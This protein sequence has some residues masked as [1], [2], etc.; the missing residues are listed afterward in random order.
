[1]YE[2]TRNMENMHR[3]K[4]PQQFLDT[5][6]HNRIRVVSITKPYKMK[7]PIWYTFLSPTTL[8]S[9]KCP[10][11]FL[12]VNAAMASRC[13]VAS[14]SVVLLPE[15]QNREMQQLLGNKK[16]WKVQAWNVLSYFPVRS[17]IMHFIITCYTVC[18]HIP[19]V[20]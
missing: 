13:H 16:W 19:E 17:Y 12:A 15:T 4:P 20:C 10:L 6:K 2:K 7:F 18:C 8:K 1:M 14:R 3:K 9:S 11:E 5:S